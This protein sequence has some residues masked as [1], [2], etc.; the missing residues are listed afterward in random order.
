LAFSRFRRTVAALQGVFIGVALAPIVP[1]TWAQAGLAL[2]LALLT[3]S[4]GGD[5]VTLERR[6]R[7]IR[8]RAAGAVRVPV[9]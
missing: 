9:G 8:P 5:V 1:V 3:W 4:F 7:A 2:A 6:G